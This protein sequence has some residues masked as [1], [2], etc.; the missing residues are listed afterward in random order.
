[1]YQGK[2][3]TRLAMRLMALTFPRTAELIGGRWSEIDWQARRWNIPRKRMKMET[4]HI[5]PLSTQALEV[6]ELLREVT[7]SGELMF[8]GDVDPREPMSKNTF[9]KRW[10]VWDT[11]HYAGARLLWACFHAATR[12]EIR[13][14]THRIAACACQRNQVSA[15]YNLRNQN[16][17]QLLFNPFQIHLL[18]T[19]NRLVIHLFV[20]WQRRFHIGM[21]SHFSHSSTCSYS[22]S[23]ESTHGTFI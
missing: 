22:D 15:A 5:I 9:S 10:T 4:P 18:L 14:R 2:V 17:S 12:A 11:R 1:M 16:H 20:G 23:R 19:S 6:L 21:V 7:G 3:V 13:A 8:P